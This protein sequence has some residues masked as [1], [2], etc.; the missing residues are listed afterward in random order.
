MLDLM[1]LQRRGSIFSAIPIRWDK[2]EDEDAR[3]GNPLRAFTVDDID[4]VV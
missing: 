3:W 2:N 1:S 4:F